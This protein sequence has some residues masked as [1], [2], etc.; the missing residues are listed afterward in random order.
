MT[1]VIEIADLAEEL[2][3]GFGEAL[4]RFYA[5]IHERT[6]KENVF[7]RGDDFLKPAHTSAIIRAAIDVIIGEI[8]TAENPEAAKEEARKLLNDGIQRLE[9]HEALNACCC[10]W[11]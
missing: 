2:A 9:D 11:S 7:D 10:P 1:D 3:D 8:D 4:G 6:P 5:A